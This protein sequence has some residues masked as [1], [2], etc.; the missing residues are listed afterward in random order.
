MKR[1]KRIAELISKLEDVKLFIEDAKSN[2]DALIED[3]SEKWM[4]SDKGQEAQEAQ[5]KLEDMETQVTE[6]FDNLTDLY[7]ED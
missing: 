4:D 2:A 6:L 1:T 5:S 3:K 7:T